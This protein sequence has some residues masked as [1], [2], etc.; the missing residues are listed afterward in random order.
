MQQP[1]ELVVTLDG[2]THTLAWTRE[3]TLVD[4]LVAR[5]IDA[6]Y[7]C[8]EGECGTCQCVLISGR[9]DMDTH[10]A[11]DDDDIADGVALGCQ[12]RPASEHVMIE[13]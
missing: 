11:L 8:R 13:F 2:V 7:S 10:G 1:A 6:P 12:A 9:V 5:G 3:D 4:L